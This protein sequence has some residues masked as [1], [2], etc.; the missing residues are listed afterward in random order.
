MAKLTSG[1]VTARIFQFAWP[2]LIGNVF[3]QMYN[4]VDAIIVG[5][6]VGKEALSGVL[7]SSQIIMAVVSLIIGVG[8]GG[9]VVVAQYFGTKNMQNVQK[10]SDTITLFLLIASLIIG[11]IGIIFCDQILSLIHL[12]PE[13]L[14]PARSF[15]QVYFAGLFTVFGYNAT[16]SILRGLGDSKTPLYALIIATI[17]NVALDLLFVIK[18][19]MGAGGAALAT[20]VAQMA[21]WLFII[22]YVNRRVAVIKFNLFRAKFDW[23]IFRQCIRIGLPSGVQQTFVAVGMAALFG[24]IN[25]FG[26]DVSA[27]Y[28]AAMR[29]DSFAALPAMNF[30]AAL[31]TFVAQN[32]G[33]NRFDRIRKGLVSTLLMSGG[34]SVLASVLALLLRRPLIGLFTDALNEEVIH[35]GSQY[36]A[37]VCSF[38]LL[39]SSMFVVNGLHRGAG[40]ALAP[41]IFSFIGL[42]GIRVPVAYWLSRPEMLGYTGVFWSIPAAWLSGLTLSLIYYFSGKWKNKTVV[43]LK[44]LAK[45]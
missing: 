8:I 16:S 27:G 19:K 4:I 5:K 45:E 11:V 39:F 40:A 15:L 2:M 18:F 44:P 22:I 14:A 1:N 10:T 7:A 21:S 26:V 38:Y 37:I 6:Y 20:V 17:L 42:W 35:V 3:Q 31:S 9:S 25:T 33:A 36:L 41:M 34:V 32:I 23:K 12:P 29:I 24:I 28:G 30:S 13:A 43:E